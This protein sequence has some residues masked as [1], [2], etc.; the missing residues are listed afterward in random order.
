MSSNDYSFQFACRKWELLDKGVHKHVFSFDKVCNCF[1]E[2]L[3]KSYMS[4]SCKYNQSLFIDNWNS[5]PDN[6]VFI[7]TFFSCFL[8]K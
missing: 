5:I 3:F 6:G 2:M 8:A 7:S 4:I 1:L